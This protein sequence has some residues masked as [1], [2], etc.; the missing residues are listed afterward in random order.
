[1]LVIG[2]VFREWSNFWRG[3]TAELRAR[4][5]SESTYDMKPEWIIKWTEY[6]EWDF[7]NR[8]KKERDILMRKFKLLPRDLAEF[9][10]KQPEMAE[11]MKSL[12]RAKDQKEQNISS[13]ASRNKT[14]AKERERS[15]SPWEEDY[16]NQLNKP[17]TQKRPLS[18]ASK[19]I[20]TKKRN[21]QDD[22]YSE[23]K[24]T[25]GQRRSKSPSSKDLKVQLAEQQ[26]TSK[27]SNAGFEDNYRDHHRRRSRSPAQGQD[28]HSDRRSFEKSH[29]SRDRHYE[30]RSTERSIS[31]KRERYSD[32]RSIERSSGYDHDRYSHK[33]S[34]D[35]QR[36]KYSDK[37]SIERSPPN[38]SQ[39]TKQSPISQRL[40]DQHGP[41][42]RSKLSPFSERSRFG[43]HN[44]SNQRS[45]R[46]SFSPRSEERRGSNYLDH[47]VDEPSNEVSV[48]STL[49]LM[50]ALDQ[51]GFIRDL[52][53]QVDEHLGK[54]VVLENRIPGSSWDLVDVKDF[55]KLLIA[56]KDRVD[57]LIKAGTVSESES[58]VCRI[59]LDNVI[60]LLQRSTLKLEDVVEIKPVVIDD[61]RLIKMAIAR[62]IDQQLTAQG[63]R[64]SQE[65]F[66][67]LVEAEYIRVKHQLPSQISQQT[68][69]VQK[70]TSLVQNVSSRNPWTYDNS[71]QINQQKHVVPQ[72]LYGSR[73]REGS[74]PF[75][76]P[77]NNPLP[78]QGIQTV[79]SYSGA[80]LSSSSAN[81]I[82]S[83]SPTVPLAAG[84][85]QFPLQPIAANP[86][87]ILPAQSAQTIPNIDWN[88]LSNIIKTVKSGP[89]P[90]QSVDD[91]SVH[92]EN[93]RSEVE[94]TAPV[95]EP[96]VE[97]DEFYADFTDEELIS[98]LRNFK[99]LEPLEQKDLI[100]HM[101]KL[102]RDE[103]DRV[104]RLKEA[105]HR[106]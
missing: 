54:A 68:Q 53:K 73:D 56:T 24:S 101:K 75:N 49:R 2:H 26:R 85:N 97:E 44:L 80:S 31:P 65:E 52:G 4:G 39:Y 94:P 3:K 71:G 22:V 89:E 36:D 91:L 42:K 72:P 99:T 92:H 17:L 48:I 40:A 95:A 13:D 87:P 43:D 62:T 105:V 9:E 8:R 51:A 100:S 15:A 6:F 74:L 67:A 102:E 18:P 29:Y 86:S 93:M 106:A 60:I 59:I 47:R 34:P 21:G 77:Q 58:K 79:P 63:Q 16:P 104:L 98:L 78:A 35:F 64:L 96:V 45:D 7:V 50:S 69:V 10:R 57:S 11:S 83:Q 20:G 27:P 33:R 84:I 76:I 61:Q 30:R 23:R 32:R 90:D 25:F 88:S 38:K 46:R 55:Y 103:P 81:L 12:I 28:R 66:N 5:I 14:E 37:R 19:E 70:P 41:E 82:P 1:M